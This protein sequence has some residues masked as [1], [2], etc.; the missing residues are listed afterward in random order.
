MFVAAYAAIFAVA[1]IGQQTDATIGPVEGESL[2]PELVLVAGATGRTGSEIVTELQASGYRVRAFVR[3]IDKAREKL[4][5][6]IEFAQG[7]VREIAS[8]EA[9]L[10]DVDA[11]IS[12][13]GAGRSDPA[14]GP[15][16]VDY[17]GVKNLSAAAAAANLRQL[18]LVSSMGVTQDDHI[19]NKMFNNVLKWKFK[20]EEAL[21]ASGVPY[22]IVRPGG[23]TNA[24]GR[25]L[26]I[27]F[28]QG[29]TEAGSIPRTDVARV[30]VA[31]LDSEDSLNKT[32]EINSGKN[33]PKTDV[34]NAFAELATD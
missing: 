10:T 28:K 20:G 33:P 27:V 14:N 31:A 34:S 17:G 30:C 4:G 3:D 1:A 13:I 11:L 19:L 2:E 32:F 25:E 22:T 26:E 7:D 24:P 21:R 6:E 15:E 18:V 9:A 5:D 29:D 8:I 16:F 12:A 23:L